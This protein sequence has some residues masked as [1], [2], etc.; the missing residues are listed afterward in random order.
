MRDLELKEI[1]NKKEWENFLLKV[2]EKTFLQSWNWGEVQE[3]IGWKI[4]RTGIIKNGKLIGICFF[5]KIKA[6]RGTYLLVPHGPVFSS[7]QT[8]EIQKILKFFFEKLKEIGK[9]EKVD[10]LRVAPL[11]ERNEFFEKIFQN[12]GFRNSPMHANAYESTLKL[13][14]KKDEQ[15]LLKQMRKTTRYLIKKAIKTKEIEVFK[16]KELKDIEI[17]QKLTQKVA[18]R[19]KF[20]PFPYTLTKNEFETFLK[21]ENALLFFGKY[22]GKIA[23]GALIIFWSK[24][25]FYHQAASDAK[26]AKFSI[27]YLVVWEAIKEAKK[28]G[29]EIF[30]FWGYVDPFKHPN[31]PWAGPSL[32]KK[33]FGGE[34]FFYVKTKDLP[35]TKKYWL[36]YIVERIRKFKRRL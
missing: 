20:T 36:N 21:D 10:F 9:R 3:K 4:W 35:L 7:Y 25:G 32:F 18:K 26:F 28:R 11:F 1:K 23:C 19:Q 24:I 8:K 29:C 30:D 31:H 22:K 2:R 16:S 34:S 12:L 33:G 15:I 17:Y 6:K 14:I 13:D 5:L 27:P